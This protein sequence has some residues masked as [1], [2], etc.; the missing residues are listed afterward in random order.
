MIKFDIR[1]ARLS[2]LA[3]SSAYFATC[4]VSTGL[5]FTATTSI[6]ALGGGMLPAC[7]SVMLSLARE[8]AST[9]EGGEEEVGAGKMMGAIAMIMA[10]GQNMLGV[11]LRFRVFLIRLDGRDLIVLV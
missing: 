5:V 9:R 3:D 10:A 8:R 6:C 4:F 7:Q 11:R 2:L 1:L